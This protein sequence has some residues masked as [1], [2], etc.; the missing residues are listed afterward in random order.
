MFPL[1]GLLLPLGLF[2][3]YGGRRWSAW[4]SLTSQLF[5]EGGA[6]IDTDA[7]AEGTSLRTL[8]QIDGDVLVIVRGELPTADLLA[9]HRKRVER[10]YEENRTVVRQ[11]VGSLRMV[12]DGLSLVAAAGSG[13]STFEAFEGSLLSALGPVVAAGVFPTLRIALRWV[14]SSILRRRAGAWLGA[15]GGEG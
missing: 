10:W 1:L 3:L 11:T 7:P 12:T 14:A 9:E 8:I 4:R 2:L 13:W 5:E 15:V 6:A